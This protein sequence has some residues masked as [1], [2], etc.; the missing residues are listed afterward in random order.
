MKSMRTMALFTTIPA[1]EMMPT[2]VM[3][4]TKGMSKTMRPMST[5]T[6]DMTTEVRMMNGLTT[7]LNW[8]IRMKAMSSM[9]VRKAPARNSWA[10]ACSSCWPV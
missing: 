10:S 7:E 9:A 4:M 6:V 8:L 2:P 3:I 5:P 1:S